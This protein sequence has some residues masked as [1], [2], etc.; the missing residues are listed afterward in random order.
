MWRRSAPLLSRVCVQAAATT[1]GEASARRAPLA[2]D[3]ASVLGVAGPASRICGSWPSSRHSSGA[4][5]GSGAAWG[6]FAGSRAC[7]GASGALPSGSDEA[8]FAASGGSPL[9]T[10]LPGGLDPEAITNA[11]GAAELD[12]L[13]QATEEAWYPTIGIQKLV[14]TIHERG[15]LPWCGTHHQLPLTPIHASPLLMITQ[16]RLLPANLRNLHNIPGRTPITPIDD[17]FLAYNLLKQ[18]FDP[19]HNCS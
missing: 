4:G 2:I 1:A 8:E 3:T 13:L 15:D 6:S 10:P 12:A 19:F 16:R 11:A 14:E 18:R 17:A 7:S 5:S 9:D